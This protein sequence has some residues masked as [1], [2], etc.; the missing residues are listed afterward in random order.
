MRKVQKS[1]QIK[2]SGL[3]RLR[4]R[5][6]VPSWSRTVSSRRLN[7]W[8]AK[9]KQLGKYG[10]AVSVPSQI[11]T[12][13]IFDT[14]NTK[15]G[16]TERSGTVSTNIC[17]HR[18][19]KSLHPN[20]ALPKRQQPAAKARTRYSMSVIVFPHFYRYNSGFQWIFPVAKKSFLFFI[21]LI[22]DWSMFVTHSWTVKLKERN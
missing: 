7:V 21:P 17:A 5:P 4:L 22:D 11:Q 15:S 20:M 12:I 8:D 6:P 9:G 18:R 2:R 19:L 14:L 16:Q 10:W 3:T 1:N 13:N